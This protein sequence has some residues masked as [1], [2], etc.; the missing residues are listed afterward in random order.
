[1]H[2]FNA[3]L[4]SKIKCYD[5]LCALWSNIYSQNTRSN[6]SYTCTQNPLKN[7]YCCLKSYIFF[8]FRLPC[9]EI[10]KIERLCGT[11][12]NRMQDNPDVSCKI[13]YSETNR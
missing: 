6:V 11:S 12:I 7:I 9:D 3:M 5:M 2:T 10:Q 13:M 4:C 1:M 8:Y